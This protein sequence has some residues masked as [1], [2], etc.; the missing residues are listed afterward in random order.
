MDFLLSLLIAGAS[1]GSVYALV[2]VGLNFTFWTTR[3]LNFGQGAVMMVCAIATAMLASRGMGLW[4]AALIAVALVA[5]IGVMVERL[6]VRPALKAAGSLGW[7]ISTLG[8][9]ILLQGIA[10]RLFGSQALPFPELLFHAAD[11]VSVGGQPL[12]LQYAAIFGVSVTAIGVLE[13]LMRRTVMGSAVR[14]VAQDAQLGEVQGLPVKW[15]V[16]GSFVASSVLAGVAGILVAQ[17]GGTIDPAFGFELVLFGFVAAVV[18]G[19]GSSA[20]ALVGGIGVGIL[21][22]LVGGYVSTAAEHGIAFAVLVLM[23]AIRPQG[24]FGRAEVMKA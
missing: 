7:V 2:A 4:S 16:S 10:A 22:K 14:A 23:L 20:G 11:V 6:A 8:F 5:V 24:L 1:V 18:G 3:T 13:L 9:G 21:S 15:I 17:I 19:M 12:S